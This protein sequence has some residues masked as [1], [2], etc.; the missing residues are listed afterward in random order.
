MPKDDVSAGPARDRPPVERTLLDVERRGA[1]D[2]LLLD[3]LRMQLD[4]D[5]VAARDEEDFVDLADEGV[6]ELWIDRVPGRADRAP[7]VRHRLAEVV[8]DREGARHARD[9]GGDVKHEAGRA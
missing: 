1:L 4:V 6:P 7:E 8:G 9:D 2:H 5:P 3:A